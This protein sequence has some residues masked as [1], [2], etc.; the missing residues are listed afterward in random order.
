LDAQVRTGGLLLAVAAALGLLSPLLSLLLPAPTPGQPPEVRAAQV[1]AAAAATRAVGIL[2]ILR[3]LG[4]SLAGALLAVEPRADG[5]LSGP[6]ARASWSW[7]L[8]I[9][10]AT[11][12]LTVDLFNTFALIPLAR[13]AGPH[14]GM[15]AFAESLELKIVGAAVLL[16]S[17]AVLGVFT[18]EISPL[19]RRIGSG[20]IAFGLVSGAAGIPGA[21]GVIANL[22]KLRELFIVATLAFVPLL[23]L[24]VR[25][26]AGASPARRAP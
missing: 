18:M 2:G 7:R 23:R 13:G 26:A 1:V 17:V 22:P 21:I 15:F 24:G 11:L 6:R 16:F 25:L 9:L 4:L 14:P 8:L 5:P 3:S 19:R 20:W 12:F 10:A